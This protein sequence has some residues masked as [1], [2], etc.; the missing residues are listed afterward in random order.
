[1]AWAIH[2]GRVRASTFALRESSHSAP[3]QAPASG[4]NSGRALTLMAQLTPIVAPA[5]RHLPKVG[6]SAIRRQRYNTNIA[7][8][9]NKVSTA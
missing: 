3:H 5:P 6:R 1:M 7:A 2:P 4:R 8:K 9:V